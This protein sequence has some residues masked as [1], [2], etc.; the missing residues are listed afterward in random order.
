MVK[1]WKQPAVA[2]IGPKNPGQA[3][4]SY[5]GLGQVRSK[6]PHSALTAPQDLISRLCIQNGQPYTPSWLCWGILCR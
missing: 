4:T 5:P 3:T 2:V 6:N 1:G